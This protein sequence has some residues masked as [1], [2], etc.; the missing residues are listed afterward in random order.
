M[1]SCALTKNIARCGS[2]MNLSI[3]Y[4]VELMRADKSQD[5]RLTYGQELAR[6]AVSLLA[7]TITDAQIALNWVLHHIQAAADRYAL[8]SNPREVDQLFADRFAAELPNR[9]SSHE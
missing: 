8:D 6:M 1:S 4:K 3:R 5:E 7:P 9:R 2:G